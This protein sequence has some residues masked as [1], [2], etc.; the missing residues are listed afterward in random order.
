[1]SRPK[2]VMFYGGP[3]AGKSTTAAGIYHWLKKRRV[4]AAIVTETA[5]EMVWQEQWQR[6]GFQSV[7]TGLQ[8]DRIVSCSKARVIITDTS[9][10]LA[11]IYAPALRDE[12]DRIIS[13]EMSSFDC[14]HVWVDRGDRAYSTEGRMQ[15]YEESL[16]KD[17]EILDM[18]HR[19]GLPY[20]TTTGD[21]DPVLRET[22]Y[23]FAMG[24]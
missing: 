20:V 3:S 10:F 21:K 18:L 9:P 2:I 17:R 7:V 15:T 13:H 14:M 1:V 24:E 8:V 19:L 22:I 4:D 23:R 5:K 6:I 16:E 12:W 11:G